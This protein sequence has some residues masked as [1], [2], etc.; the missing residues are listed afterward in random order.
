M[1]FYDLLPFVG[2]KLVDYLA[3]EERLRL[4]IAARFLHPAITWARLNEG[5]L[6]R[7]R[8]HCSATRRHGR[9][10][11]QIYNR[12]LIF[13]QADNAELWHE[14]DWAEIEG[15]AIIEAIR[16]EERLRKILRGPPCSR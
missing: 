4:G 11:H 13:S 8:L 3:S 15:E 1:R 12:L 9:R 10:I 2:D 16:T 7:I 14:S 5:S 6:K